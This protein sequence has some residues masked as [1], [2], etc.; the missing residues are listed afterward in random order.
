[1]KQGSITIC[2]QN[3]MYIGNR[4]NEGIRRIL[5]ISPQ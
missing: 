1:M 5:G 4:D 2:A 3:Q